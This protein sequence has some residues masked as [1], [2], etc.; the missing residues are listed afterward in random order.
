MNGTL[1]RARLKSV[2]KLFLHPNLI[3]QFKF[4]FIPYQCI[5]MTLSNI[6]NKQ[7]IQV[8]PK[9]FEIHEN[10]EGWFI[11]WIKK[12][13]VNTTTGRQPIRLHESTG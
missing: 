3:F 9:S 8:L 13:G 2:G 1:I 12:I 10:S 7:C 4:F 11:F 6:H 5:L